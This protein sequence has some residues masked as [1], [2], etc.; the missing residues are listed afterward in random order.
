MVA[1]RR[2]RRAGLDW[3]QIKQ[4]NP[5][6]GDGRLTRAAIRTEHAILP[7]DSW[8]RER[9]NHFVDVTA[10]GAFNPGAWA[11]CRVQ[12]P[13]MVRPGLTRSVWTCNL[14]GSDATICVAGLRPDGRVGVEVYRDI[15][16]TEHEPVTAD[17]IIHE[18]DTSRSGQGHS[19]R[20]SS[21]V[22]PALTCHGLETAGSGT[23]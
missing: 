15:R 11:A 23:R 10:A 6:L 21:G 8:R 19:L 17:R 13:L 22:A 1:V 18:L 7:P 2:P 20:A 4:A 5:A 9:L 12:G 16:G 14:A 3:A